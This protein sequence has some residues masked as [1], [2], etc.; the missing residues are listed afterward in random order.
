MII[1]TD[2]EYDRKIQNSFHLKSK[3]LYGRM[4]KEGAF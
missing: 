1:Q 4:L 2:Q 3:G